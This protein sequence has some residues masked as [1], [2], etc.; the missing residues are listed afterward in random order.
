[1]LDKAA[2]LATV[3]GRAENLSVGQGL[4]LRT[5]KRDR[6]VAVVRQG[7]D[8]FEIRQDGF[9]KKTHQSDLKGLKKLL[10]KLLKQKF[11][12]S[13]KIRLYPL[14]TDGQEAD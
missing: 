4:D 8:A 5:Y 13:R 10:K 1:M 2:A 12:R 9:G 11:P 7:A 3:L 14:P 6:S